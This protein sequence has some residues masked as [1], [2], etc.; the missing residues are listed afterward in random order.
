MN[1]Q[2]DAVTCSPIAAKP[3]YEREQL[4]LNHCRENCG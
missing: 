3:C 1:K 2:G 4:D